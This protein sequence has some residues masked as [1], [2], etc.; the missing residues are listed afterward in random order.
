MKKLLFILLCFSLLTFGSSAR[1]IEVAPAGAWGVLGISGGGGAVAGGAFEVISTQELDFNTDQDPATQDITIP[2]ETTAVYMFW[3]YWRNSET[4]YGISTVTLEAVSPDENYD[5]KAS[6]T[7]MNATGVAA[8]YSPGTGAAQT[9]DISW[10]DPPGEGPACLFVYVKGGN[11]SAARDIDTHQAATTGAVTVT[12]DSTAT[13][14][15]LKFDQS[16]STLPSLSSGWTNIA[17]GSNNS[18]AFRLSSSESPGAATTVC[19]SEDENYSSI[20]GI[21]IPA[22]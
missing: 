1:I 7:T 9:V 19:N 4:G 14:L 3:S 6:N 20:V 11:L 22:E 8:W 2:A 17:T 13:D 15:V 10:D 12:V 16:Y 5:E 21:S 18:H